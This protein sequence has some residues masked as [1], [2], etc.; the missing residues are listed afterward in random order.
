M[1]IRAI[2][3]GFLGGAFV[4]GASFFNDRI[5]RQ[6]YL[7]GNNMP[8]SVYGTLILFLLFVNPLMRRF[9][10]N[11]KELAVI[12][13]MTLATC[14]IPGSG[15]LRTFTSSCILPYH[16]EKLDA[17]WREQKVVEML[18]DRY[19][20]DVNEENEDDV[21]GSF[22]QGLSVGNK[23]C[24]PKEIPLRAWKKPFE[25]WL[26]MVTT[27]WF[28]MIGLSLFIHK[29]WAKHEHLPYPVASFAN[30]LLPDKSDGRCSLFFNR[31]FWL[32]AGSVLFIHMNNYLCQWFPEYLIRIP[33]QFSFSALGRL[34]PTLTRGGGWR[35]LN[36]RIFFTVVGIAY[37]IP[38]DLSFTF[39]IGP[40]LWALVVGTFAGYGINLNNV[41]EGSYWYTGL[42]PGMFI[43]FGSNVGL[44]LALLYTG[45]HYYLSVTKAAL[46]LGKSAEADPTAVWGCRAFLGLMVAFI[47]QMTLAGIDWQLSLIYAMVLVVFYVVMT[48][49]IC[50]SGLFHLQSN[51][52]P[53]VIIWG[54]FGINALGAK[55]LLMM[56][57]ISLILICD[58]RESLMPFMSNSL[59]MLD[60][61][62]ASVGK[63]AG[64]SAAA[65]LLGLA[66]GLSAT[67]YI[68]YDQ[69]NACWEGW[70]E[71]AVPT[72]QF[73]NALAVKRKLI[74]QG[75]EET[76]AALSGWSRFAHMQPNSVCMYSFAAGFV[77]VLLFSVARLR[78][79]WWPL[80][81]LLFVTWCTPHIASFSGAF[82]LGWLVKRSVVKY[83]G[84]AWYNRL[85]PLMYGLIAGE[86]LSALIP[87]IVGAIYY[88][89]TG[90]RPQA[91]QVMLG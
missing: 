34:V 23:H 47:V 76:S 87:S 67:L 52:F 17:G 65:I 15:F 58:P 14:C 90:D 54:L 71:Q 70:A 62:K 32:G 40:F 19:L 74:A 46:G 43:L 22:V 35:L 9:R 84:N 48:R 12:M 60:L 29:Q 91:F 56:Q 63:T 18:P 89:V 83:G 25:L 50:E 78:F 73:N 51:I 59:K 79:R 30:A 38:T 80:H 82:L 13:T 69:G 26:P 53:G 16:F 7:V 4:C 5:L 68:Q 1:T 42:K 10:L 86:I 55:T 64:W 33:T 36:P 44:F 57:F 31:I 8:V 41:I 6:T 3:L 45:R 37:F 81:P 28:A 21:L 11:G 2:L 39:G 66:I 77:L 85:K 27:L 24:S 72:M 75:T 88:F 61:R 20:V 49:I